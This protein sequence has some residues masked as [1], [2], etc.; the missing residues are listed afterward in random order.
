MPVALELGGKSPHIVFADADLESAA[1]AVADGIFEAGGQSC[2]AG[3]RL[4]VQRAAYE[5]ML[6]RGLEKARTLKNDL[7]D[8]A[9]AQFGPLSSFAHRERVEG[10]VANARA[11]GATIAVGGM[12]PDARKL[13]AGA[14]Y[15]PTV[16]TGL[17]NA[18][19]VC[20]QEIFGPVLCALPF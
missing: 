10:F 9:G 4:F 12:R 16:I 3:S 5:K 13:A 19:P 8:A 14:F 11:A 1:A 6:T 2:V 20:Q 17:S 7:P 15:T 18:D